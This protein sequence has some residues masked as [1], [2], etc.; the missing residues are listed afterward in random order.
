MAPRTERAEDSAAHAVD[1]GVVCVVGGGYVGLVTAVCLAELGR[2]VRVVETDSSRLAALR[3]ASAPIYEPG[4]D[5]VLREVIAARRF[6]ATDDMGV[7]VT[8]AGVVFIAVG[9]PPHEDAGADLDQ[10]RLALEQIGAY[11]G[12][13]TVVA[14]KSTVPPGTTAGLKTP[15][16]AG[17]EPIPIVACPEFL[18]EGNALEDF[19][20]PPRIVIGGAD[21]ACKRVSALFEPLNAPV[22]ITDATSAELVKYGANAFLAMK[23][24][25]INEIARICELTGGDIDA[26]ADGIGRDPRIGKSFLRAGLGFGGSCFP[27]DL[28]ALD[29]TASYHG[30]SF[31]M[32]KAALEVNRVQRSRFVARIQ[33]ALEG[34]T[35]ERRVAV[36]GLAFKPGTDDMRQAA[37]IDVIRHLESV[38]CTVSA[39]DPVAIPAAAPRLRRTTLTGDPYGC[40]EGADVVALVTEWPEYCSLDWSR[41]ASL[42]RRRTVVDGRNCLDV[43]AVR[44]AGFRY[45]GVGRS[46]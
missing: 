2:T 7:A 5:D 6:E 29:E 19:R 27:K 21:L 30:H 42:V 25:F 28:R 13:G 3:A 22:I 20:H 26:V 1:D 31:W 38:G 35:G 41:I 44:S 33:E 37:S 34:I 4:L 40:V 8:G 16:P 32:L 23:I 36:L 18:R 45:V 46:A 9:T 39:C 11:A 15:R 24:S 14:I 10:V 17:R 12:D 43:R